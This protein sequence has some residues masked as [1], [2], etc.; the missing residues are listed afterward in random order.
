MDTSDVLKARLQPILRL[1]TMHLDA[2][3]PY[4]RVWAAMLGGAGLGLAWGIAARL[5]MRLISTQPEFSIPGTTAIL[6]IA[7][8]FGACAGLAFAARRRG[9]RRWGHY[10]PRGLAVV[11]FLPL[12]IAGGAPLMLTVLLATLALTQ[13]A[14]IGLWVLAALTLLVSVGTDIAIPAIVAAIIPAM[15][16]ALTT[17]KWLVSRWQGGPKLLRVDTW[18]ERGGRALLLLLAAIGVWAVAREIVT[19]KPG[20]L[21]LVAILYYIALL[22]PVF[23]ALRVG[24]AQ[25]KAA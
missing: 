18:L 14:L 22:Y 15:A 11:F 8:L 24:L 7:T 23:V 20:V 16:V 10:L 5:W 19:D 12:G 2:T 1:A 21:A 3:Q 9:W 4:P 17:W 25:R 13:P 6:V